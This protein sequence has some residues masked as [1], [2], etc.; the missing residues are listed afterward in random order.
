MVTRSVSILL[1]S[2]SFALSARAD[3]HLTP[4]IVDYELEGVKF[5]QLAFNTDSATEVTYS[6]PKDWHYFG[7][8]AK[9]TMHPS[10]KVQAEGTITTRRIQSPAPAFDDDTIAHLTEEVLAS[11]PSGSTDISLVS[12]ERSPIVLGE[13][14]TFLVITSYTF[15][16][17]KFNRSVLF[18]NRGSGEQVRFQLLSRAADFAELQRAFFGSLFSIQNL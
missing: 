9:F 7:S 2:L 12:Q 3:L 17:E 5:T 11:G 1:C 15:L 13:K 10:K 14:E 18:L 8:A 6:P 16:G 4:R